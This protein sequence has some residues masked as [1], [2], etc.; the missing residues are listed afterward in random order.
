[1]RLSKLTLSGFKSFARTT[2]LEFPAAISAIVGPNGSGK[3]NVAEA[4]RW[5]L[6]EQSMKTLRGKRGE[7]LIFHGSGTKARL[8]KATV[9]LT[10][11]NRDQAIPTV[12]FDEVVV[13]RKIFRD[14]VNE[15]SLNGS[16]VRLKDIV[17]L[18]ARI[19]LG[20]TKHNIIG[21]GEVDRVLASS[22]RERRELL[23]EAIGLRLSQLKKR[24]AERKLEETDRNTGEVAALIKEISPHLK[25]LKAQAEKGER[26]EAV[27]RELEEYSSAY[28]RREQSALTDEAEGLTQEVAPAAA[29]LKTLE[30]EIAHLREGVAAGEE[31]RSGEERIK[32]REQ[33]I[34]ALEGRRREFERELGRIEGRLETAEPKLRER[35][36]PRITTAALEAKI[37]PLL[38]ELRQSLRTQDINELK[39]RIE[40]AIA[41]MERLWEE[42]KDPHRSTD[43]SRHHTEEL[44]QEGARIEGQ[45]ALLDREIRKY[46]QELETSIQGVGRAENTLRERFERLGALEAERNEVRLRL[47]R[48]AF[49]EE[50]LKLRHRD[51]ERIIEESGI[52]RQRL[53]EGGGAFPTKEPEELKKKIERLKMRLEEIGGIDPTVLEEYRNTKNRS[54][55]LERELGDLTTAAGDLQRLVTELEQRIEHDFQNGFTKIK[56]EFSRYFRII[57]AGGKGVLTYAQSAKPRAASEDSGIAAD[58]ANQAEYGIGID[59][60]L[61]G[62]RIRGL[63]MLSGGERALVS[64]AL[65]FAIT[66]TNPPPFLVMDETDAALDEAN[67]QKYA[68]ILQELAKK[69]Q[70]ILITHNRETMQRAGVLYGLTMG[71]DGI[72]KL[73]SLKL[74]E[75]ESY[76]NR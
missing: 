29:K 58:E 63:A 38:H 65:L 56:E 59:V 8:G 43:E 36:N 16:P 46:R 3:S 19:G 62:K 20:E 45:V 31:D 73:L 2:V 48:L 41:K 6:G 52:P 18:I 10:F 24:E 60:D 4:I 12:E 76:G 27:R 72:S 68:A 28:V 66:A 11:D 26:R 21:Q 57:F 70:L 9:G 33:T 54:E 44:E 61:P 71:E 51:L 34:A 30:R 22:P 15:Y 35:L 49:E 67:S 14:G 5:V 39:H 32:T 1:M 50:K 75:A 17:E 23:E 69:T 25:F 64:I 53:E 13:E 42:L 47:E 7:D 55:F 37:K 74:E 40:N